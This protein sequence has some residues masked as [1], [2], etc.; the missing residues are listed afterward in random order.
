M[1][2]FFTIGSA[3]LWIDELRTGVIGQFTSNRLVYE[4]VFVVT[5]I[6]RINYFA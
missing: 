3:A 4:I 5:N 1:S 2:A 6:V